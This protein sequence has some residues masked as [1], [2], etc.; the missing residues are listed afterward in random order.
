[1]NSRMTRKFTALVAEGNTAF[2]IITHLSTD[3]KKSMSK[4]PLVIS[5]GYSIIFAAS[6]IMDL[7]KQYILDTDPVTR[8]EAIKVGVTVKKNHCVPDRNPYV[9]TE[10]FAIFGEGIEQYLSTLQV[11]ID[12]KVLI[13]NGAFIKDPDLRGDPKI[14]DGVKLQWQGKENFR[15]YMLENPAYF[16]EIQDRIGGNHIVH[17]SDEEL[18][19]VKLEQI[20]IAKIA[21]KSSKGKKKK[22]E[23]E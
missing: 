2:V 23:Q 13:Q 1:M 22:E 17:L 19:E 14:V 21:V 4:D 7:R 15:N 12:Q 3:I 5:G 16:Q 20:E 18:E 11:A 10:Y 8:E 9:K 6:I